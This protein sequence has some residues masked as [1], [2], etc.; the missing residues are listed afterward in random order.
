[1][2]LD[3]NVVSIEDQIAGQLTTDEDPEKK[4]TI[5]G[6]LLIKK[7]ESGDDLIMLK[8]GVSSIRLDIDALENFSYFH[9]MHAEFVCE[10]VTSNLLKAVKYVKPKLI[11]M[12]ALSGGH[13]SLRVIVAHGPFVESAKFNP[14]DLLVEKALMLN[15]HALILVKFN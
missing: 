7:S 12:S 11:P 3:L 9:G 14:L 2:C 10:A 6:Y 8:S 1:M 15:A 13:D 5:S 4:I